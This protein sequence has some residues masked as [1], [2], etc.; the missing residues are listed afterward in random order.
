EAA[1]AEAAA[2]DS[3]D[4]SSSSSSLTFEFLLAKDAFFSSAHRAH[5]IKA[6]SG[7]AC[8]DCSAVPSLFCALVAEPDT[9]GDSS[10][11]DSRSSSADSSEDATSAGT[12]STRTDIRLF[13]VENLPSSFHSALCGNVE[14]V[15][16][17]GAVLA[18]CEID[19]LRPAAKRA[20]GG[21]KEN[22]VS[23][24]ANAVAD[25]EPACERCSGY[26]LVN[27]HKSLFFLS[28]FPD[29]ILVRVQFER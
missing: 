25:D 18:V 16:P 13:S 22:A 17:S 23:A 7:S 24:L 4:V 26:A 14:L 15:L 27:F 12:S 6:R 8:S 5:R 3:Q 29:H 28:G 9:R 19:M 11:A 10:S 21:G 20:V 2:P 1:D